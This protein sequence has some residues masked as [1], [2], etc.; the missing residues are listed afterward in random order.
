ML[1]PTRPAKAIL[2]GEKGDDDSDSTRVVDQERLD[3]LFKLVEA[4]FHLS[5][6]EQRVSGLSGASKEEGMDMLQCCARLGESLAHDRHHME[7]YLTRMEAVRQTLCDAAAT[8]MA[9]VAE[10][11]QLPD[12]NDVF[13]AEDA[14]LPVVELPSPVRRPS[15]GTSGIADAKVRSA[16]NLSGVPAMTM[17]GRV[18][19]PRRLVDTVAWAK[20]VHL[21]R[22]AL[23][24]QLVLR[25]IEGLLFETAAQQKVEDMA[26]IFGDEDASKLIKLVDIYRS[27]LGA[28]LGSS[29]GGAQMRVELRS[30]EILVTWIAY[31]MS[32]AVARHQWWQSMETFGVCLDPDDL[33]HLVLSG[34][35]ATDAAL[36]VVDFL[37]AHTRPQR[38]VFTLAD[39]GSATFNLAAD[40]AGESSRI[41][42]IWNNEVT[43]SH[44]RRDAHWAKVKSLQETRAGIRDSI[45]TSK[46]ELFQQRAKLETAKAERSESQLNYSRLRKAERTSAGTEVCRLGSRLHRSCWCKFCQSVTD[47]QRARDSTQQQIAAFERR[48]RDTQKLSPVLQPLPESETAALQVLFFLHMPQVFRSLGHLS[49]QAQQVLLPQQWDTSMT[50][51]VKQPSC[52]TH[53]HDYCNQHRSS[54]YHNPVTPTPVAAAGSVKLGYCGEL[55]EPETM[56]D[57]CRDPSDGVWHPDTLAPGR[58]LWEGG[59]FPVDLRSFYFDPFS[60]SVR[61]EWVARELTEQLSESNRSLQW[62]MPQYGMGQ[63]SPERGNLAI[64]TQSDAPAWLNKRQYLAFGRVRAYPLIQCRQLML[65]LKDRTLPLDHPAVRTLVSQALF[66]LGELSSSQPATLLWRHDQADTFAAL[67]HELEVSLGNVSWQRLPP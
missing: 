48:L 39:R 26:E 65:V 24:S 44:G 57:N 45:F 18:L 29:G 51:A 49:F 25:E 47:A 22:G 31:V 60:P 50:E 20:D 5:L 66:Q 55:G 41:R 38:A 28:F 21:S 64:A 52:A 36:K 10:R 12:I 61:A 67:F 63:T 11:Y 33:R 56:V 35:L 7:Q 17:E 34:K 43:A 1:H 6:L 40:V 32:F 58:M 62:A 15:S 16:K 23:R 8:Q 53:W 42:G 27:V 9:R 46:A 59:D 3:V 54:N 37:R 2:L 14:I 13:R 19:T 30:R 4:D